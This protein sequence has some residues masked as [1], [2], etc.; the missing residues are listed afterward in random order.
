MLKVNCLSV[1]SRQLAESSPYM[2][3]VKKRNLEVLLCYE[4][5][6]ELV[7]MNLAQYDKKN[8]KSIENEA[9]EDEKSEKLTGSG[10]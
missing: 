4:P 6:D 2:E 3:A 10:E 7:L 5:Y 8:L 9:F 1:N